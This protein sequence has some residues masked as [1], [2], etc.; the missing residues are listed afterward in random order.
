MGTTAAV[1]MT[2]DEFA[3]LPDDDG[4]KRELIDGH[5]FEMASG[6]PVHE[7]VKGNVIIE[8]A[9]WIKSQS[10]KARLQGETRYHLSEI[11][12][13]QPDVSVVVGSTLDPKSRG[14][15]TIAPDLV[16]EVVSSES[17]KDLF[18]KIKTLLRAGTRAAV[19]IYPFDRAVSIHRLGGSQDLQESDTLRLDDVLP[20]FAVPVSKL[21]EDL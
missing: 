2:V 21:F 17:A 12:V 3:A 9:F 10:L 15:I 18:H 4:V 20:G 8:L 14:K 1:R 16:V 5:V 7:T 6:G 13:F 11:D 19:L